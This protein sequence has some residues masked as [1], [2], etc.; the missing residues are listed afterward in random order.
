MQIACAKIL[1]PLIVDWVSANGS[2]LVSELG[3]A[4]PEPD[5]ASE[6]RRNGVFFPY[7]NTRIGIYTHVWK[8]G[9]VTP[10]HAHDDLLALAAPVGAGIR[11]T[12]YTRGAATDV[13]LGSS[14]RTSEV[15][16]TTVSDLLVPAGSVTSIPLGAGSIHVIRNENK[17]PR[18]ILEVYVYD[19][20]NYSSDRPEGLPLNS[21]ET[22]HEFVGRPG[23]YYVTRQRT[24][25]LPRSLAGQE[26]VA[27]GGSLS[28]SDLRA[29]L[30]GDETVPGKVVTPRGQTFPNLDEVQAYEER[31]R[32]RFAKVRV[33]A[34][35]AE[36]AYVYVAS[37]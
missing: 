5:E 28:S 8:S 30:P 1:S 7:D 37:L 32:A 18:I 19:P 6:Y 12:R 16:L 33:S 27:A 20:G 13:S 14:R 23:H 31:T 26:W 17:E 11:E 34:E 24:Q 35:G 2:Q 22:F 36:P 25:D 15:K 10:I 4:I 29:E 21:I 9:G 3:F